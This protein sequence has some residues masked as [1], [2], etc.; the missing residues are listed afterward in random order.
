MNQPYGGPGNAHRVFPTPGPHGPYGHPGAPKPFP[1]YVPGGPSIGFHTD[2]KINIKGP[3][4]LIA[5]GCVVITLGIILAFAAPHSLPVAVPLIFFGIA[6]IG[7]GIFFKTKEKEK[8]KPPKNA[9]PRMEKD[10][11]IG[12]KN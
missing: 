9:K 4:G 1:N 6:L 3:E 8:E 11:E 2:A 7:L 5:A 10:A 12:E